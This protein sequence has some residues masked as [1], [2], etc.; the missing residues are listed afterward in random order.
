[1]MNDSSRSPMLILL[2]TICVALLVSLNGC[3]VGPDYERPGV[4]V[5]KN[6]KS[7]DSA[8]SKKGPRMVTE[9]LPEAQWWEAFE[10][11]ELSW[12][13]ELALR[14]NHDVREAAFRV[15][16]GRASIVSAEPPSILNLALADFGARLGSRRPYSQGK[17]EMESR[18]F[19]S[20]VPILV[21]VGQP[22]I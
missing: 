1:M 3:L 22:L 20:R 7:L 12:F 9:V 21:W 16:E 11:D 14:K 4:E 2:L 8:D 15:L 18:N 19:L 17:R 5:P 6:W 13:I 10:S